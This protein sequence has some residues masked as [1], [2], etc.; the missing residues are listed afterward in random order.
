VS[1]TR[2]GVADEK[3][4]T[5]NDY[6]TSPLFDDRER[7]ALDFAVDAASIPNGVALRGDT[8]WNVGKHTPSP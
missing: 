2:H 3:M 5:I 6:G 1:A 7:A 4:S 8:G